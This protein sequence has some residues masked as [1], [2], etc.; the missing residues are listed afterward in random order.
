MTN[1]T[2]GDAN[3]DD[4]LRSS[5]RRYD[6]FSVGEDVAQAA[7]TAYKTICYR[8]WIPIVMEEKLLKLDVRM[9]SAT[10]ITA[11]QAMLKTFAGRKPRNFPEVYARETI[12]LNQLPPTRELKLQAIRIGEMGITAIPNEVSVA[13]GWILSSRARSNPL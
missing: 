12:L 10:E 3:C 4:G 8:D 11:A 7:Y 9:P 6:H 1:G 2:S 5:P 13:L